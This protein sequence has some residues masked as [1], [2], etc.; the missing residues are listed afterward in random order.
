MTGIRTSE[1]LDGL[2]QRWGEDWSIFLS[3]H[4]RY[5]CARF[6]H[7]MSTD[8]LRR[9][10]DHPDA[11]VIADSAEALAEKLA[12]QQPKVDAYRAVSAARAA[13][14]AGHGADMA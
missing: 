9:N 8:L 14:E 3:E 10:I 2:A 4:G 5:W 6:R 12:D 1:Q 11:T 13:R 7:L